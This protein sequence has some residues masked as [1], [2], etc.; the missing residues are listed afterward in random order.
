MPGCGAMVG[1][2]IASA[3]KRP[4]FVVGK[5][6]TYI[7]SN[8]SKAF[9]VKNHEIMVV[10]DSY[11]SDIRMAINYN[12]KAILIGSND[13][14]ANGNVLIMEDLHKILSFIKEH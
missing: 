1:S 13:N 4:D 2:I 7:L 10:G 11:E 9:G 8:I 12:S 3:D 14:A 6:N 5:P